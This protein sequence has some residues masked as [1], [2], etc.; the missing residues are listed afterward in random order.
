MQSRST[1]LKSE[2][3]SKPKP[4]EVIQA[5]GNKPPFV[6]APGTAVQGGT[7]SRSYGPDGYPETDRDTPHPDEAGVGSGDHSHDWGRPAG[8]GPP[9]HNDRGPPRAPKPGDPPPPRGPNTP[10]KDPPKPPPKE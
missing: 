5:P 7:G 4:G 3:A 6:G 10:P 8:G 1:P 9:T 2:A